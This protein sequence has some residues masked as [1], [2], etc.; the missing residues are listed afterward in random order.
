M[1][2][3]TRT[4]YSPPEVA[5]QWGVSLHVVYSWIHS[6]QLRAI[7]VSK[8]RGGRAR[9]RIDQTDLAAFEVAR[10]ITPPPPVQRRRRRT[11]NH[12]IEYF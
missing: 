2:D 9:Y 7:D 11:A 3:I 4:K 10:Q 5:R 6:G 8:K 1:R 12:V